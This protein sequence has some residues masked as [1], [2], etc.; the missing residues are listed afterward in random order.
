MN[1]NWGNLVKQYLRPQN[2]YDVIE[3]KSFRGG[4]RTTQNDSFFGD[5]AVASKPQDKREQVAQ[6]DNSTAPTSGE[7]LYDPAAAQ[8]AA[9]ARAQAVQ[10]QRDRDFTIGMIDEQLGRYNNQ[11]GSLDAAYGS[12]KTSIEDLYNKNA[13]R[14]NQQMGRGLGALE[15][16]RADTKSDFNR[17][18]TDVNRV[19]R[20]NYLALQ[21]ALNRAGAGSSSA[22][23][24][25]VPY[26]VS[27][28]ASKTRG[29]EAESFGRV[30]RDIRTKEDETKEDYEN[31]K[32]D[33]DDQKRTNLQNLDRD[34]Q[35]NRRTIL[36]SIGALKG[37]RVQAEGGAWQQAREA[38]NPYQQ[39]ASAI[40]TALST[41][42]DKYRNPYEV[43]DVQVR[44]ADNYNYSIDPNGVKID[45]P[46]GTG[47]D[48]D[49]SSNYLKKME[50]EEK[51]KKEQ[52]Q[53]IYV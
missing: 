29:R 43:K 30:Y 44:K 31:N 15:T 9:Q 19:A 13:T 38:M 24:E 45:D 48:T 26:A 53:G 3:G 41:L 46:N 1:I 47:T 17:M 18:D 11:L 33:L 35:S 20:N 4:E 37:Q 28:D 16:Q 21:Q 12:G 50:D 32:R 7:Y 6:Q 42:A 51:R 25:L 49:T 27:Q 2:D 10:D 23:N 34:N 5:T 36:D 8:Q 14:L 52:Q 40:D 22:M 39:Q